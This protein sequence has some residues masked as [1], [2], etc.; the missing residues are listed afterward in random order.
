MTITY[1]RYNEI[2]KNKWDDCIQ[3]SINGLIYAESVYLDCMAANWD[4]LILDDYD[5]VMPLTWKK[6]FGI[7]YL[8]QPAFTQQ[9]GIFSRKAVSPEMIESFIRHAI[10]KFKFAEFTL[11][12]FNL[13]DKTNP[14]VQTT[15]RNNFILELGSGYENLFE[16]YNPYIRQRLGRLKKFSLLYQHSDDPAEAIALYREL[17]QHRMPS[18]TPRDYQ[19]FEKLCNYY[20]KQQRVIIRKAYTAEKSQL[21][22][23]ILLLKDGRRLYNI[24]S[25]MMP[26][27]KKLL[28]NYF[29][30]NEVIR[31]FSHDDIILDFEGSDIPGVSY[32]YNKFSG[33]NQQY[34]FIKFNRLPLPVKLFRVSPRN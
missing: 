34:P 15:M 8:Y 20:F 5:A 16:N 1:L 19:R 31:E 2:D 25:C 4:G 13:I 3:H 12:Y 27:G 6:K 28:A 33:F 18:V 23:M 26:E 11:N 22:A 10:A 24:I 29:L 14:Q 9:G 30:Y 21:L 17:Y 7:K 32:F